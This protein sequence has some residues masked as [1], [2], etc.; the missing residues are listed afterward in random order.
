MASRAKSAA[1]ALGGGGAAAAPVA[2]LMG[3]QNPANQQAIQANRKA[4]SMAAKRDRLTAANEAREERAEF[5][6]ETKLYD[7]L[8]GALYEELGVVGQGNFATRERVLIAMAVMTNGTREMFEKAAAAGA[9]EAGLLRLA[10]E[11]SGLSI[12][13]VRSRWQR[14]KDSEVLTVP[15]G[16]AVA[17]AQRAA[18][19]V[20]L[21][22]KEEIERVVEESR[23]G[24]EP[25]W[26][27]RR[28]AQQAIF[29][30]FL[31]QLSIRRIGELMAAWGFKYGALSTPPEG[32]LRR[33]GHLARLLYV[34]H[35][36]AAM[37]RGA[38]LVPMDESYANLRLGWNHGY[39]PTGEM[40]AQW[41]KKGGPGSR[42]CFIHAMWEKGLFTTMAGGKAVEAPLGS[43][44]VLP[45]A[46]LIVPGPGA[47]DKFDYKGNIDAKLMATWGERFIATAKILVPEA[48]TKPPTKEIAVVMDNAKVHI[49]TT[50]GGLKK[51]DVRYD[52]SKMSRT[53]LVTAL[54]YM[55]CKTLTVQHETTV[56]GVKKVVPMI[57]TLN[58]AEKVKQ[59]AA[60]KAA[61]MG[62]LRQAAVGW[63]T[64]YKPERLLNDLELQFRTAGNIKI[65]WAAP[66]F[67]E[68]MPIELVWA[69][70]KM[71]ARV[72]Y[73]GQRTLQQLATEIHD[74][75]TTTKVADGISGNVHGGGFVPDAAGGCLA[76]EKLFN[77]C[78][79][80][81]KRGLQKVV[82]TAPELKGAGKVGALDLSKVPEWLRRMATTYTTQQG[83]KWG[84]KQ[85]LAEEIGLEAADV[86][87]EALD[88]EEGDEE[89]LGD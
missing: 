64:A 51:E 28:F 1:A 32:D 58:D 42:V 87:E 56:G 81:S 54:L 77:H 65:L 11:I 2:K 31:V 27:T 72:M 33:A 20:P 25:V 15:D 5:R 74:G 68:A 29:D 37:K 82:D 78:W 69:Q 17:G 67:P 46:Y 6:T 41:R 4:R 86:A 35:V 83:I 48:F 61:R 59:G 36:D 80:S 76:A 19:R 62:E 39:A 9:S 3:A 49:A 88:E 60:G 16:R 44:H 40:W 24:E 55:G 26:I 84:I 73:T 50:G 7:T 66:N 52:I 53:Q 89:D 34:L 8:H 63:L 85:R 13:A 45:T 18:A 12:D 79:H 14:F 30:K 10:T 23:R 47:G 21:G 71:Y 38:V 70:A 75:L 43:T 22:A 57:V